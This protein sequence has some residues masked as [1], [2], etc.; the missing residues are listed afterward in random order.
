METICVDN[1]WEAWE[2]KEQR[3]AVAAKCCC[4]IKEVRLD[5]GETW[6][7]LFTNKMIQRG[8]GNQQW[9]ERA[10]VIQCLKFLVMDS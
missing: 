6:A 8:D 3:N 1:S 2:G 9:R 4:G 5:M 10:G 7:C